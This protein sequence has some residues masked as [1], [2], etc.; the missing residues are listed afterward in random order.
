MERGEEDR[1]KRLKEWRTEEAGRLGIEP[2]YIAN[3]ALLELVAVK[4]PRTMGDLEALPPMR[5]WQR[6]EFGEQILSI[7]S[8]RR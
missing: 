5:C 7:V 2:G 1:L 3:N 8:P 4:A 6:S